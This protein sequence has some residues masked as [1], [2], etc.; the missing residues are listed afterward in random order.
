MSRPRIESLLRPRVRGALTPLACALLAMTATIASAIGPTS[1]P[2]VDEVID[3]PRAL[4][5]KTREQVERTLG[6][7]RG[8]RAKSGVVRGPAASGEELDYPGIVIRVAASARV[9]RVEMTGADYRLPRGLAVGASR[10]E[11]ERALGEPQ[12]IE[13][14]RYLYLYSDGYPDTV[15]FRFRND[16]VHSI[17]WIYWTE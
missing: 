9:Q 11:V 2:A 6:P 8:V 16:R 17:E 4:F 1:I 14:A 7:P 10:D 5:G 15:E 13:D 3:A 12:E